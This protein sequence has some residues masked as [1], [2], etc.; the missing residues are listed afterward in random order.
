[1][2]VVTTYDLDVDDYVEL[3]VAQ[4]SGGALNSTLS[5]GSPR[6]WAQLVG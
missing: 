6:F 2:E 5:F 1:M 4:Y 3:R